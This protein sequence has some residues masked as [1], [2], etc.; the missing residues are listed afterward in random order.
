MQVFGGFIT[1]WKRTISAA[2]FI[3]EVPYGGKAGMD[4]LPKSH[5]G[6]FIHPGLPL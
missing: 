4:S 2:L 1:K 6:R 3:N 5:Y